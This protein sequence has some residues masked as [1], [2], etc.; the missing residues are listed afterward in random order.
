[1]NADERRLKPIS[2]QIIGAAFAVANELGNGFLEKIYENSL[3]V[4]LTQRGLKVEQQKRVTVR[5]Q[6]VIVGDYFAD[7]LVADEIVVEIKHVAGLDDAHLAQCLNY[8]RATGLKLCL[9]INF[10]APQVE[11]RRVVRGL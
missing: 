2:E 7:L 8:L 1:M 3:F 5:Y 4:D 10:G 6:G 11:V 9:L